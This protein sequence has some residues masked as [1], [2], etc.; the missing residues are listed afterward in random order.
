MQKVPID[1]AVRRDKDPHR[2]LDGV[3]LTL[4]LNGNKSFWKVAVDEQPVT[5][6]GIE[7]LTVF[8]PKM[9]S[10]DDQEIWFLSVQLALV[11][12]SENCFLAQKLVFF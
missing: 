6:K 8:R 4:T 10:L 12:R 7:L 2:S 9:L 3:S 5:A 1:K 11:T